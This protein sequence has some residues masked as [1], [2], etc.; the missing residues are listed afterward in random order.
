VL[1]M[2]ANP[3]PIA[4]Y[5]Q[6]ESSLQ[7]SIYDNIGF[8]AGNQLCVGVATAKWPVAVAWRDVESADRQFGSPLT[9]STCV[10]VHS[11]D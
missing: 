7:I 5:N 4:V 2:S 9:I 1:E 11:F 6:C 3:W 10:R 8:G